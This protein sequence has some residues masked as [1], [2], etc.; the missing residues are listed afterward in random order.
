[1]ADADD[2]RQLA[3]A[4]PRQARH[5]QPI[6]EVAPSQSIQRRIVELH[7]EKIVKRAAQYASAIFRHG[8]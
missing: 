3:L 7:R 2:V 5:F 8:V 6:A 4:L 1:M